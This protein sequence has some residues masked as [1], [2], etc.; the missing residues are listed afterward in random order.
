M[1]YI[2][3]SSELLTAANDGIITFYQLPGVNHACNIG[4]VAGLQIL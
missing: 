3:D 1:P 4:P 2:A